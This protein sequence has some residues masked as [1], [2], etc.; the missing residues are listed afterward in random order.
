[1]AEQKKQVPRPQCCW[2]VGF[3]PRCPYRA[4]KNGLCGYHFGQL[5]S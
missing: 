1:M 3:G 4:W 5:P 2:Q